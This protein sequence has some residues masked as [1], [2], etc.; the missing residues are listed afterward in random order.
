MIIIATR[1]VLKSALSMV[2]K[3]I[4]T[5]A[6][7]AELACAHFRAQGD[8]VEVS[9]TDGTY[10]VRV[11]MDALV[12]EAGEALVSASRL[13]DIVRAMPDEAVTLEADASVASVVCGSACTRVPA[14]DASTF[15]AFPR[16]EA[17]AKVTLPF[18]MLKAAAARASKFC[19]KPGKDGAPSA[20]T[21]VLVEWGEGELRVVSTDS[22]R[23]SIERLA[24]GGA[25]TGS[26]IVPQRILADLSTLDDPR[27]AEVAFSDNQVLVRAAGCELVSRRVEG[28]FVPWQK[29]DV[30][31]D[32]QATA[33]FTRD[34][35]LGAVRR[36]LALGRLGDH[37]T[38][39]LNDGRDLAEMSRDIGADGGSHEDVP[40]TGVVGSTLA[41]MHGNYFQEAVSAMPDDEVV[42]EVGGGRRPV[43]F[44]TSDGAYRCA[45]MPM[46][47]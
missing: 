11:S 17:L 6:A 12:E 8:A 24:V 23:V 43:L 10:S 29:F 34:A 45:V 2:C 41:K 22:Y 47:V 26:A 20:I 33:Y 19:A 5:S 1:D 28:A 38:L 9:A 25:G 4:P 16:V 42:V 35:L 21:G 15:P 7:Y 44:R 32:P 46:V 27:T 3:A 37:P 18:V 39:A 13:S 14:L 36:A 30:V 40:C 31:E